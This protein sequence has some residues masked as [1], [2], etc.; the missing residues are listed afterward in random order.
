MTENID[1]QLMNV[2]TRLRNPGN[3]SIVDVASQVCSICEGI[4][5]NKSATVHQIAMALECIGLAVFLADVYSTSTP[6]WA[7]LAV[8]AIVDPTTPRLLFRTIFETTTWL[9]GDARSPSYDPNAEAL[10]LEALERRVAASGWTGLDRTTL[11]DE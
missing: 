2:A 6:A 10:L 4:V 7:F 11:L 5:R 8:S 3:E 1:K 9:G